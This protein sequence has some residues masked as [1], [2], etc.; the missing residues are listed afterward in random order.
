MLCFVLHNIDYF[1]SI[2]DL[3][4]SVLELNAAAVPHKFIFIDEVDFNL[5]K[6][7]VTIIGQRAIVE[8][9]GRRREKAHICDE[10]L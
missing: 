9:L 4:K 10:Q 8:V 3:F 6:K 7:V 5:P 1:R 2:S